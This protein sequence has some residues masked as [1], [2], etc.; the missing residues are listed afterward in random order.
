MTT[1][2]RW[3]DLDPEEREFVQEHAAPISALAARVASCPRLDQLLAAQEGVLPEREQHEVSS[4]L[5]SCADCQALLRDTLASD[6]DVGA[7]DVARLRA[8]VAAGPPA[9]ATASSPR[10]PLT[11]LLA[12]S[13]A[14][15]VVLGGWAWSLRQQ[16][17][18]LRQTAAVAPEVTRALEAERARTQALQEQLATLGRPAVA[19]N[20]P[21]IDLEPVDALRGARPAVVTVPRTASMVTLVLAIAGAS[22]RDDYSLEIHDAAGRVLWSGTGLTPGAAGTVSL[23]VPRTF[24]PAGDL[25]LRLSATGRQTAWRYSLRIQEA[26]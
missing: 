18:A 11:L 16:N 2:D 1:T 6:L 15:V 25:S 21:F 12:A 24:L 3:P 23:V 26:P 19:L 4:H 7:A 22:A 9:R 10:R 17:H 14:G 13:L 8:R 5:R 20:V